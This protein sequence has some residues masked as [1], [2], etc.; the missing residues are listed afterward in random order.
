VITQ[1]GLVFVAFLSKSLEAVY[2]SSFVGK[3]EE[4]GML[5][6]ICFFYIVDLTIC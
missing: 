5:I 6:M 4:L 1:I 2:S 3:K